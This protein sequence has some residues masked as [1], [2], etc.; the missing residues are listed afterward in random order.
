MGSEEK[1]IITESLKVLAICIPGTEFLH[2]LP[3]EFKDI[4]TIML[5]HSDHTNCCDNL[6][7][8]LHCPMNIFLWFGLEYFHQCGGM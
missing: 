1:E 3:L 7:R 4:P 2:Q 5:M 8:L 6:I